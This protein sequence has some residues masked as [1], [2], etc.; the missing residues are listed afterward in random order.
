MAVP[1]GRDETNPPGPG[2]DERSVRELAECLAA[3]VVPSTAIVCIGND[4]RGD[5]GVGPAVAE[6]LAGRV[7]WKLFDTQTAPES[8]LMKIAAA[9][10]E[11][12]LLIDAIVFDA[13]PGAVQL[14]RPEEL[15]GQGPSTHGPAP[16]AFLE[17]LAMVHPCRLAVLGIR[18]GRTELDQG[19]SEPV[20]AAVD[21]VVSALVRLGGLHT[22]A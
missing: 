22:G 21:R 17:A 10:P 14:F 19:I 8:F 13:P 12:V 5:D 20:A 3:F 16:T 18:P 2:R 4:M 15:A 7:P 6:R 11:S 9:E 1:P